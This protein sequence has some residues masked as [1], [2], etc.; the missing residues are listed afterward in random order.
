MEGA[1]E[2][3]YGRR[4]RRREEQ[5][6]EGEEQGKNVSEGRYGEGN[7][8]GDT[9]KRTLTSIQYRGRRGITARSRLNVPWLENCVRQ[10][11]DISHSE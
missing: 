6:S 3:V 2:R 8:K 4:E 11:C 9:L 10:D 7:F 1:R 5:R